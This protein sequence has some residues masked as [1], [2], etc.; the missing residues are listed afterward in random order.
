MEVCA[1]FREGG[2]YKCQALD[3]AVPDTAEPLDLDLELFTE[4]PD[5]RSIVAIV[6]GDNLKILTDPVAARDGSSR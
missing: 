4:A 5:K 1:I 3:V 2:G 6:Y